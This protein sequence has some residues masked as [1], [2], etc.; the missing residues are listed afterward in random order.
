MRRATTSLRPETRQD[1]PTR[2]IRW[3]RPRSQVMTRL[4][5]RGLR[6]TTDRKTRTRRQC[7]SQLSIDVPAWITVP[8]ICLL[9]LPQHSMRRCSSELVKSVDCKAF[10]ELRDGFVLAQ[11]DGN[12]GRTHIV[13]L[14]EQFLDVRS[15]A[16]KQLAI[17]PRLYTRMTSCSHDSCKLLYRARGFSSPPNA[18]RARS[19]RQAPLK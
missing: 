19:R 7:D 2:T 3:T 14:A 10:N 1:E 4:L 17:R 12:I 9:L 11:S 15:L 18:T 8:W 6:G 13:E 16:E 5:R